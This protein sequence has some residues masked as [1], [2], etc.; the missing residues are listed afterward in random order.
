MRSASKAGMSWCLCDMDFQKLNIEKYQ[1]ADF[2]ETT[3]YKDLELIE[4]VFLK[5]AEEQRLEEYAKSLG[6]KHFKRMLAAYRK[7]LKS[8]SGGLVTVE[9]GGVTDFEGQEMEMRLVSW[10][11][12]ETGIWRKGRD[13]MRDYACSHPIYPCQLRRNIDTGE[14]KVKLRYRR[15]NEYGWTTQ[16]VDYDTIAN[17]KNIISLARNGVSVTSGSRAQALVDYLREITDMNYNAIERIKTVSY[18]GWN[19][20]GFAPYTGDVEFDGDPSFASA[21]EALAKPKGDLETW[22]DTFDE[23]RHYS[24]VARIVSAASFASC[25]IKPLGIQPFF[26]HLWSMDSGTGKS[27]AQMAGASVWGDP[28]INGK[29]YFLKFDDTPTAVEL[30]AG[31]LQ[32]I[33]MFIDELQ[34]AKDKNGKS[35]FNVYS[36]ASGSG[37]RRGT[38]NLGL[39]QVR[40]WNNC[41]ITSGES[42]I[43]G[44]QDGA[45][46]L[47]R[48]IE[49]ECKADQSVVN[50]ANDNGRRLANLLRENYGFAGRMFIHKLFEDGV[51]DH[52][53]ALYAK[54]HTECVND[55]A[56]G[57][58]STAAAALL[59]ADA[60]AC[61][62]SL[63]DR[64]L[65]VKELSE[66]LK[67]N[68]A[69]S[70]SAR[71]YKYIIDWIGINYNKFITTEVPVIDRGDIYGEIDGGYAYIIRTVFDKACESEGINPKALLSHLKTKNLLK[72][73]SDN[74]GYCVKRRLIGGVPVDCVGLR[75]DENSSDPYDD[76]DF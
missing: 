45:G 1:L 46:A 59:T 33:P 15:G 21:F 64:P 22:S 10:N 71:G 13:G 24:V 26:V 38:K 8:I 50:V 23:I 73:R 43:V 25:L 56:T 5:Q 41:F 11:A 17:A 49:I 74:K 68:E 48:V 58:Q 76:I 28:E 16:V 9:N 70:A 29:K 37:K 54:F 30:F 53:K 14:I 47:N 20:E 69:V 4:D 66:F 75:L 52:A 55:N 61:E 40:F 62:W 19:T 44:S 65:T 7:Q 34:L 36:L 2:D 51:L 18:L 27:I 3:P 31:F 63:A 67:T 42:P 57:K 12:D 32:S 6:Y 72:N 35:T 39:A 60:L